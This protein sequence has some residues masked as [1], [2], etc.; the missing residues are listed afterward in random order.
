MRQTATFSRTVRMHVVFDRAAILHAC[1]GQIVHRLQ[2]HPELRSG[3]K[4]PGKTQRGVAVTDRSP[5]TMAPIRVA[6]TR[7]AI[8]SAFTDMPSGLR[9]SSPSTSP[10]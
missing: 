10:G 7:N 3:A 1:L 2:A 5:L 8:A 4:E 6:G 9:N